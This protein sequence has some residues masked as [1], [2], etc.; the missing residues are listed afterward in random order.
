M[1]RFIKFVSVLILPLLLVVV[2]SA[3]MRAEPE[4]DQLPRGTAVDPDDSSTTNNQP[5]V[6]RPTII[7]GSANLIK[8]GGFDAPD[9]NSDWEQY[10]SNFGTPICEDNTKECNSFK[11]SLSSTKWAWLGGHANES[12]SITQTLVI[13]NDNFA[14]LSFYLRIPVING[15][16]GNDYMRVSI[17]DNDIFEV[18]DTI[19]NK[20]KYAAYTLVEVDVSPYAD[21]QPHD[22]RFYA[23]V[24]DGLDSFY[25]DDVSLVTFEYAFTYLPL[26]L[27]CTSPPFAEVVRYNQS[28]I[29]APA[30]W[31]LEN[32]C[33]DEQFAEIT[34]AVIDTGVDLDHP[35]L[36]ANI[37]SGRTY[38]SGTSTPDDDHGHGTHVAGSAAAGK[39]DIGVLGIA[40][41]AKILPIK[42]L[43]QDGNG[44]ISDVAS[45]IR[46]A[47]D[48][49]A[50]VINLSLGGVS[51]TSTEQAAVD[52]A[53]SRGVLVIAAAG[54]CGSPSSY[55]LNGCSY[56]DQTSYPAAFDNAMAVAS[57]TS[58]DAQSSFSTQGSYV[59]I[60]APGSSIY[61]AVP[62]GTYAFAS[63]TSQASPH[64]AG[65]AA[66]IWSLN[67]SL[68][69]A[70]VRSVINSTAVDLGSAGRD[71]QFGYGRID[72]YAAVIQGVNVADN[73]SPLVNA[74]S[75]PLM[76]DLAAPHA[77]G[78]ILVK[79]A[80]TQSILSADNVE[81]L[82][83]S[84][85]AND[86]VTITQNEE[87]DLYV[88]QV[89]A[90]EEF[91]YLDSLNSMVE[92]EY[93]ELNYLV[94]IR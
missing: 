59:E 45:A 76:V 36:Q 5:D 25:V 75:A 12:G 82:F 52:Y 35:D 41:H 29:N 21:G 85:F 87:L 91:A 6:Q 68:T 77:P 61:S 80:D 17:D 20:D 44:F 37:V 34:I 63:G 73:A 22:I 2:T 15:S 18:K 23:E 84:V 14:T 62:G 74:Q 71:I 13:S 49:G 64:V 83:T 16:G 42:V 31:S 1:S 88:V 66:F 56:V 4:N 24:H 28:I 92:V 11:G 93:A 94:T 78:E 27:D 40:P 65:L 8:D 57:T 26:I 10:S 86:E 7:N 90:G 46:W 19:V 55:F 3:T 51:A 58:T 38:V 69:N 89:P 67:P 48:N 79:L 30:M 54:N 81:N 70:Q 50:N 39:N 53:T 9:P 33:L 32:S 43:N 60:A 47:A 72:A